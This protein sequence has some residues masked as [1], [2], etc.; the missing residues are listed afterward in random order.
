MSD[1]LKAAAQAA[2]ELLRDDRLDEWVYVGGRWSRANRDKQAAALEAALAEQKP[3][4]EINPQKREWVG[5]TDG[6]IKEVAN[7]CTWSETYHVDFAKAVE[8]KLQNKNTV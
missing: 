7:S 1:K 4:L 8:A 6:E 5:L 3:M 2:L